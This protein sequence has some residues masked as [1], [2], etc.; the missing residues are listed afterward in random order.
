LQVFVSSLTAFYR[1][2]FR[3]HIHHRD[4]VPQTGRCMLVGNH[5]GGIALDA[6]MVLTSCFWEL[7]PPRLVHAMAEKFIARVPGA[8]TW[9]NRCGQFTGLPEHAEKLLENDRMLM[10][11][12]EGAR[13]TKKLYRER[14]SLVQFGTGF[15]RLARR[16]KTPIIPF[17]FLGGGDA[18]PTIYNSDRLG[19]VLGA[20]YVPITPWL[21]T[22]PV[23]AR[24]DIVWGAPIVF[25]G[26]GNEDDAVIARDVALVKETIASLIEEGRHL[27][28]EK[29]S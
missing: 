22:V 19:K 24:L 8:A 2:Y 23:P 17:A 7:E 20:P 16:M 25:E 6:A 29:T 27:R 28:R 14:Y 26:S 18:I 9:T 3:I 5:S 11:F 12:P 1:H 21:V 10:V 15:V 4:H 13:G